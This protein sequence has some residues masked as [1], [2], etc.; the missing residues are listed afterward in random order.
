MKSDFQHSQ[1]DWNSYY[2]KTYTTAVIRQIQVR[3][4]TRTAREIT[5]IL[6]NMWETKV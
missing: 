2:I 1:C 4:Y 3:I 5:E 6:M